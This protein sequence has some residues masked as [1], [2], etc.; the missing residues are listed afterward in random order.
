MGLL[1]K[2][3]EIGKTD[4]GVALSIHGTSTYYLTGR[5]TLRELQLLSTIKE[6]VSKKK[7]ALRWDG[8]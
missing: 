1:G 6:I 2:S 3:L 8:P 7:V 5:L 4:T